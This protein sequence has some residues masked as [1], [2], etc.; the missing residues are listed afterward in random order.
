MFVLLIFKGHMLHP[1]NHF[2]GYQVF[3]MDVS[4]MIFNVKLRIY[5]LKLGVVK[6][7]NLYF[8]DTEIL[9]PSC[10]RFSQKSGKDFETTSAS[11]IENDVLSAKGANAIAMRWSL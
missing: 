3:I 11:F 2:L 5:D 8:W 1:F 6:Y 10:F 7:L 9:N 4:N